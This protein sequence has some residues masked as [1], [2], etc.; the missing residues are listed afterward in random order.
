MDGIDPISDLALQMADYGGSWSPPSA[1]DSVPATQAPGSEEQKKQ[2]AKDFE[3]VLLTKLFDQVKD[4]VGRLSLDD[5]EDGAADQVH[6]MFWL[7]LAQDMANKGGFGMWKEIYQHFSDIEAA[8][9][10]GQAI[11]REL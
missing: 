11:N 9:A 1:V 2:I 4:S 10:A 7:Y 3:S 8:N 6:G 5:E